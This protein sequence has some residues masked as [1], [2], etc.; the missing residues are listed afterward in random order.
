[1]LLG[2]GYGRFFFFFFFNDT[3]TTEIYTLSLHD[4]LP[5]SLRYFN[6]YGPR[7]DVFGAYTEVLIR[8]MEAIDAGR[9]P[10][11]FGDGTDTMDFVHVHDVARANLLAAASEETDSVFNVG[12]GIE[13]SLNALAD[14]LLAVMASPLRPEYEAPRKVNAVRRRLASTAAA[15]DR[16]GFSA[17][18]SLEDGLRSLVAWWHEQRSAARG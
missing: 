9:P 3:A 2:L 14:T 6:V 18:I 7:M 1:L 10:K 12:S 17:E 16:I 15:R 5:I 13:T 11:I 8:W 4:A